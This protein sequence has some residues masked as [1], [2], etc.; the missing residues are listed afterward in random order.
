MGLEVTVIC[1]YCGT[2]LGSASLGGA[3]KARQDAR[4]AGATTGLPG[5]R[6]LCRL[7]SPGQQIDDDKWP[8]AGPHPDQEMIDD[9]KLAAEADYEPPDGHA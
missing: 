3:D 9:Y 8:Q 7:C 1:D 4:D 6:D 2:I 5:G